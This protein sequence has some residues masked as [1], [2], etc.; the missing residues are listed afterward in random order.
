MPEPTRSAEDTIPACLRAAARDAADLEAIVDGADR[1][2]YRELD[3]EVTRFARALIARG[4]RSG[5]RCAAFRP[6]YCSRR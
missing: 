6:S 1:L 2:T 4:F 5:D 3:A